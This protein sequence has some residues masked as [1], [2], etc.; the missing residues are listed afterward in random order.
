MTSTAPLEPG[1]SVA[2]AE[3]A[4]LNAPLAVVLGTLALAAALYWP[5]TLEIAD[6][7]Q[8]TVRRRYTHGWLVLAITVWLVWRDRAQLRVVGL[9]PP[10]A[11]WIVV[12]AGSLGWLVGFNSGLLAVTTLAMPL[13]I[14]ATIWA[15]G[16]WRLV[17]PV[18]FAVL[19]LYFALPAWELL[20]P[21]LQWLTAA[22]N[23]WLAVMVGIPV[24]MDEYVIHIPAGSFEIAGGCSGLHFLIVA[25][26]IAT[27]QG[28]V[29]RDDWR[30]RC[31]L[32]ALAGG[33]AL[34]TN[35]LRVFIII[36]AGHLTDMQHFLVKVDHYYFGWFL[37]AFALGLYFYIAS[38]VPRRG[39][40]ETAPRTRVMA[41]S[42]RRQA[43]AVLAAGAALAL[44]PAWSMEESGGN[45]S[46]LWPPPP[47]VQGWSGPEIYLSDWR[48]VFAN[49]DN[50]FLVAYYNESSGDVAAFR[51]DYRSQRQ[52]KELRG[53]RNSVVGPG[54][55]LQASR[56][57][58]LRGETGSIPVL[59][60]R[61]L[62]ADGREL[63]IWSLFA[64]DGRP[65]RMGLPG[66]LAYG[67]RSMLGAPTASVIAL[68][69]ECRPDCARARAALDALGMQAL[70]VLLSQAVQVRAGAANADGQEGR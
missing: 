63:L 24:T 53:H 52:G 30:T 55:R 2:G 1:R 22:V 3:S 46:D 14:L 33:L 27:L 47:T 26:A 62:A 20:N 19:F 58:D 11:G 40:V 43:L 64:V 60:Q 29:D 41:S 16:G 67:I 31:R 18:A 4:G 5:T 44:G 68:S 61:A 21:V 49:P 36:V 57:V 45:G 66:Q 38:R 6:L 54:Y 50:E 70:P 65:D 51:A 9:S 37:F 7:W 12:A 23:L 34:V 10:G 39:A 56:Q 17:R 32:L 13:I 69:A 25:L 28:Q 59:E 48:P 15:A 42:R 35:W 8:D